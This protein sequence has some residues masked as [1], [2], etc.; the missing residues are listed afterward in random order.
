MYYVYAVYSIFTWWH[1]LCLGS[2]A[3]GHIEH[4]TCKTNYGP[5]K[6]RIFMYILLYERPSSVNFDIIKKK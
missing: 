2:N 1:L 6:W 5:L 4:V 3:V